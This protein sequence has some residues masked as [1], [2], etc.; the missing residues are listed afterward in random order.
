MTEGL[1]LIGLTGGIGTGKSTVAR[2]LSARGIPV[3]DADELA[4]AAVEPGQPALDDLRAAWPDTI[5]ADGRLDRKALAAIV[6]ADPRARQRLEGILHPRIVALAHQR[7][8]ALARAGHAAAFYEASLLVETGRHG[9]L[10]GLVVVDAPE[11]VRIARVVARDGLTP[12]QVRA[13]IAAQAPM[14]EKRRL[15][16]FVVENGGDVEALE[17][18]VT[19]LLAALGVATPSPRGG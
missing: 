13:R 16:D 8:A 5:T 19:A 7:A 1:R 9:D 3:I 6:F 4:R 10:D 18:Q 12:E 2:I 17:A 11:D 15:A 14:S